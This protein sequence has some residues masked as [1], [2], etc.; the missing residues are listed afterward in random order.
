VKYDGRLEEIL[1]FDIQG[2]IV[3][4]FINNELNFIDASGLQAGTYMIVFK[5]DSGSIVKEFT[6]LH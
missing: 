1:I 2:R 6:L 3:N 4:A 5:S